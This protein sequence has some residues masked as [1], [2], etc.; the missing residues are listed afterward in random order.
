MDIESLVT[1]VK[2]KLNH[3]EI[4]ANIYPTG[5]KE[6]REVLV[7]GNGRVAF[8]SPDDTAKIVDEATDSAAFWDHCATHALLVVHRPG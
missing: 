8:V 7:V 4:D 2:A 1:E 3:K 5:G 6:P